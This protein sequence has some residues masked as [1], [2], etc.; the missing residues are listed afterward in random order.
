MWASR[1]GGGGTAYGIRT[2]VT[3]VRGRRPRPLDERGFSILQYRMSSPPGRK[4]GIAVGSVRPSGGSSTRL[5][6]G[7]FSAGPGWPAHGGR[8]SSLGS[9]DLRRHSREGGNPDLAAGSSW[10]PD[11]VRD[12]VGRRSETSSAALLVN[13]YPCRGWPGDGGDVS[14]HSERH[15]RV[16]ATVYTDLFEAAKSAEFWTR[17]CFSIDLKRAF[18]QVAPVAYKP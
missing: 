1:L 17:C 10:I 14:G 11:Q 9:L 8:Y 7:G 6:L 16:G 2:R 4:S 15:P 3:A 18:T 5:A 12:D 13:T